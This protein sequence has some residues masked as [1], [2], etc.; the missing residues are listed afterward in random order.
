LL[1]RVKWQAAC[2]NRKLVYAAFSQVGRSALGVG[3][4]KKQSCHKKVVVG[5]IS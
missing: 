1:V 5:F 2:R 3:E 4:S